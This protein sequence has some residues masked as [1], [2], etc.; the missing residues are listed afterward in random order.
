MG[1]WEAINNS[2]FNSM[3]EDRIPGGPAV[4]EEP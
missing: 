3:E 4:R 1:E 2:P